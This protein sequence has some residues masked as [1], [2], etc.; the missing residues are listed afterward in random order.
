M[1]LIQYP[2]VIFASFADTRF[3]DDDEIVVLY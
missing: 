1:G 2:D 3:T